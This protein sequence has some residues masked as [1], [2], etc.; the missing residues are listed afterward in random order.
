M[1][2]IGGDFTNSSISDC[3]VPKIQGQHALVLGQENVEYGA[4][5]HAPLDN[6]TGYRV[7]DQIVKKIGG[8]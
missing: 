5:W 2:I 6:I 1:M 4:W 8:E 3:D 7:P